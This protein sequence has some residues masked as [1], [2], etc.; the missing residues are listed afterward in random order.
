MH[1]VDA[2]G[3]TVG[4][5]FTEGNPSL[6]IPAT[7]VSDD[8]MNDIQEEIVNVILS[9]GITL[10]KGTQTQL[11]DAI[12]SLISFGGNPSIQD[13]LNNQASPL[14]ITG[15]VFD[16]TT[17]KGAQIDFEVYR[18]TASGH[19][20]ENGTIFVSH[21]TSPDT[22]DIAVNSQFDDAGVTFSITGTG[23]VQYISDNLAGAS[24]VGK[25]RLTNIRK[26]KQ[27]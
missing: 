22:W 25:V 21:R 16:K 26:F 10:V 18:Q 3:A 4:N 24:Y 5:L 8:I 17:I 2:P 7:T 6:G 15:L 23:Q 11:L 9:Q 27:T 14:S 1:R 12:K 19:V 20:V 13:I